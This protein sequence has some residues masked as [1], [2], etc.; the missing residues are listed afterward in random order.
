[1]QRDG[2]SSEKSAAASA[3]KKRV[4]EN[5]AR[6]MRSGERGRGRG[7]VKGET[8]KIAGP[9]KFFI[10]ILKGSRI[11]PADTRNNYCLARATDR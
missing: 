8:T 5:D 1:M 2:A 10:D 6:G 4:E 11:M 3:L 9:F 7:N